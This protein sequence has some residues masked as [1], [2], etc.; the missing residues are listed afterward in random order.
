M[1]QI[2][3]INEINRR[4]SKSCMHIEHTREVSINDH[5]KW[6]T[7]FKSDGRND[8]FVYLL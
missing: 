7:L 3:Y 6:C 1:K 4:A 2:G 8:L 5:K